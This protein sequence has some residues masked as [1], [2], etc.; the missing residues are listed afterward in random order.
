MK[1]KTNFGQRKCLFDE[2][3]RWKKESIDQI[4]RVAKQSKENVQQ[5]IEESNQR[6]VNLSQNLQEK[7]CLYKQTEN[8]SEIQ[9]K[10]ISDELNQLE[11]ETNSFEL[12]KSSYEHFIQI[13]NLN[14]NKSIDRTMISQL[15]P[16]DPSPLNE[17]LR[18]N[19]SEN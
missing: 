19:S 6:L 4:K 14:E 10:N 13:K 8:Y 1:L 12:I 3:D 7:L 16:I 18:R 15:I 5:L 11:K 9:L 2:I 17:N